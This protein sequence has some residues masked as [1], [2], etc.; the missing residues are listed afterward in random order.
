MYRAAS[1]CVGVL[2]ACIASTG[3]VPDATDSVPLPASVSTAALFKCA[4]AVIRDLH[5]T[6]SQ[7]NARV[8]RR[9]V[10]GGVFETGTFEEANV[11]GYR[12]RLVRRDVE[13]RAKLSVRAA[14]P[15]FTDLGAKPALASFASRLTACTARGAQRWR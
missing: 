12:V 4:D 3:C 13:P 10:V 15:Y 9:D 11:M 14:G 6:D 5:R 2:L 7:W 8:T 1:R